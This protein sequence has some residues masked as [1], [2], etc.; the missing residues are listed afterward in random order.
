MTV[1]KMSEG[2]EYPKGG[3]ANGWTSSDYTGLMT[4]VNNTNTPSGTNW[5]DALKYAKEVA[6]AKKA[7]QPDEPVFVIFLTDGEPTAIY[8]E[9]G[10]AYHYTS[11]GNVVG[12]G[13]IEAYKPARPDAKAIVDAGYGFYSIFTFNPGEEQT[14]YL[15]RLVHYAYTGYD[16]SNTTSGNF[17]YLD[18]SQYVNKYFYNA[19]SP[20]SLASAFDDILSAITTTIGHGNVS[21]VDGLTTDAMISTLIDGKANGFTY[22]VTDKNGKVLYTVTATGNTDNPSVTFKINNTT[23]SGSQVAQKEDAS[24]KKY[25]SV[26][27][28]GN[29]Y[30]MALADFADTGEGSEETKE[31]TWDLSPIGTLADQCTYSIDFVV[32]PNQD[33]YDYVAALNN[34]LEEW[35]ETSQKREFDS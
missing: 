35:D 4:V 6:D 18:T 29:E 12:G 2:T 20:E 5:Q 14:R 25:Y 16:A 28:N 10:G 34:G 31:L 11:N 30:K 33:A 22:K 1:E 3:S 24:G 27:V 13:F 26:T 32:W 9:S 17:S 15:K 8:G 7:A 19:D 21:I 23:Y